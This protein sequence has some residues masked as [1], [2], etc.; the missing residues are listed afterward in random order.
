MDIFENSTQ[1]FV[2]HILSEEE[3]KVSG[4]ESQARSCEGLIDK[5]SNNPRVNDY[6]DEAS[7]DYVPVGIVRKK[8]R[9]KPG[10]TLK[11]ADDAASSLKSSSRS[12]SIAIEST[13]GRK[14]G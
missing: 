14:S 11:T 8:K 7:N 4:Y 6:S 2:T 12:G 1:N 9:Q 5:V 10:I 3:K 13:S